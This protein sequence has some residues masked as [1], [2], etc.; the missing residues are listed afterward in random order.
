MSVKQVIVVRRDLG[1]R[2]GKMVSQGA[3]ASIAFLTNK[4]KDSF[5]L[6]GLKNARIIDLSDVERSWVEGTF[7]KICV[8]VDSLEDLLSIKE[9]ADEAGVVCHLI[10]DNGTTEFGGVPTYT[11]LALGPDLVERIDPLTGHLTLL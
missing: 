4:Y 7:T 11:C 9:A 8:S 10:Q 6:T 3:H 2:K 5:K 1:M